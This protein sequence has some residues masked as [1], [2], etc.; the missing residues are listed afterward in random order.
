MKI[1]HLL[2]SLSVFFF[3]FRSTLIKGESKK[4]FSKSEKRQ[5]VEYFK[6]GLKNHNNLFVE[7]K[8]IDNI[9]NGLYE[10]YIIPREKSIY[11]SYTFVKSKRGLIFYS[12]CAEE[13]KNNIK[14]FITSCGTNFSESDLIEI[15]RTFLEGPI[16]KGRTL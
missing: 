4:Y 2:F 12:T 15:E 5:L 11:G 8:I 10:C 16:I 14:V 13:N 9:G 6:T 1:H 7:A 3:S